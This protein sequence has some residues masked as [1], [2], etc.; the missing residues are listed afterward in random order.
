[1]SV[2]DIKRTSSADYGR[3]IKALV[4]GDPGAGKTLLSSTFP[5]PL[6]LSAEGGLMSIA[7][8]DV[9]YIELRSSDQLLTIKKT[10]E[11]PAA[12]RAQLLGV[13]V[14]TIIVD[15][16]DEVQRIFV[17][18]RL[19]HTKKESMQLQDYGWLGEQMQALLRGLRN[20]DMHV[21]FTCHVKESKD[22][23]TG[24]VTVKPGLVGA[25]ADQIPAFVDLA[26]LLRAQ[27]TTKIVNGATE[28]VIVRYLQ[29]FPDAQHP[30]I[31]DRSGKLPQEFEITFDGD[32][33]RISR[34]IYGKPPVLGETPP[35]TPKEVEHEAPLT[36][37]P[38]AETEASENPPV[39]DQNAAAEAADAVEAAQTPAEVSV[40]AEPCSDCGAP[41]EGN[42]R[43]LSM[44]RFRKVLCG[45][46]FK[47]V[48]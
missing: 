35:T 6:I 43:D 40:D 8:R 19:E 44:I 23:A 24:A 38:E 17:K 22:D 21:V 45:N 33:D 1:M 39:A 18:E 25:I 10:L 4:C 32:Y 26:L 3:F 37:E 13:P 20:L 31:K 15:T 41:S 28:R 27:P 12:P 11:Q 14:Q 34:R 16:I 7:D 46:C 5:D 9:P 29:T 2:L 42:W 48:A 47:A 36:P 30:W